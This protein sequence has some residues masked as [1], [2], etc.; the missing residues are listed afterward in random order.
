M[1]G[2]RQRCRDPERWEIQGWPDV[3]PGPGKGQQDR[4]TERHRDPGT[5]S[6]EEATETGWETAGERDGDS[7]QRQRWVE[8]KEIWGEMVQTPRSEG[9][10]QNGGRER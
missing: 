3:E 10:Q 9:P 8:N 7:Q 5:D 6:V 1:C 2:A 4:R